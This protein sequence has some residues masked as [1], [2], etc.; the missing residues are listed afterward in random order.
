MQALRDIEMLKIEN[1]VPKFNRFTSAAS[2]LINLDAAAYIKHSLNFGMCPSVLQ[3]LGTD[4]HL[5]LIDKANN[6]EVS[7]YFFCCLAIYLFRIKQVPT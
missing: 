7:E 2:T 5:S 6:S 3:S 1:I 4:R